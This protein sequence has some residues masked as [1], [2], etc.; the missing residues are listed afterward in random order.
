MT[1]PPSLGRDDVA[2][3]AQ[4]ARLA[5]GEDELETFTNQL[6]RV[7]EHA[8]DVAALDVEG[9]PP[10]T[11]ALPV[12]NVL[13]EDDPR[14]GLDHEEVLAGAP[15]TEDGRFKVPRIVGEAP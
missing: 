7:I 1:E 2:H 3:V 8:R 10:T 12:R 4:L 9:V 15:S 5:L 13:R 6:A 11:H 14:P